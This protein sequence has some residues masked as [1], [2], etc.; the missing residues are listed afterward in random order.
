[1]F[2]G[3]IESVQWREIGL[4]GHD[5]CDRMRNWKTFG[6]TT[7]TSKQRKTLPKNIT[8]HYIYYEVK[9]HVQMVFDSKDDEL[10]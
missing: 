8:H 7:Q 6:F 5:N 10:L 1:M 9:F 4:D 3:G 2:S